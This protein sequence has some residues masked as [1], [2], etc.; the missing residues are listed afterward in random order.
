MAKPRSK[1]RGIDEA[2]SR[3]G[4][5]G[6]RAC[7]LQVGPESFGWW[8]GVAKKRPGEVVMLIRRPNGKFLLHTKEFY[9]SGIYRVP[10][11]GIKKGEDLTVA[12]LRESWEETGLTVDIEQFLGIV[13]YEI[14]GEEEAV[15]FTSYL[16]L[17]REMRGELGVR[18]ADEPITG[19]REVDVEDLAAVASD[20]EHMKEESWGDWGRFRAIAHCYAQELLTADSEADGG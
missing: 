9:P 11:G 16:F 6:E 1:V 20:L 17:L 19:Y 10:S 7:R 13:R 2:K 14:H 18:D 5:P 15:R 12:V 8:R 4:V 3:Y